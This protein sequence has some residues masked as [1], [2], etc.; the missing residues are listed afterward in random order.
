MKKF[1]TISAF[2]L[3]TTIALSGCSSQQ[4]A[5]QPKT[6]NEAVSQPKAEASAPNIKEGVAKL[7]K[8][9]KQVRKAATSGDQAKV[10]ENGP[11]LEE[12]WSSFEDGVKEKYPD[13]YKNIEKY[14][15]PAIAAA[16]A[17][18]LDKDA[19]LKLDNQLIDELFSFSAQL[20]PVSQIQAGAT[21]MLET[22]KQLKQ[23]IQAG[24]QAKV[25]ELGPKLEKSWSSFEDGVKPRYGDLYE[26]LEKPLNPEVA[27]SQVT[28]LD[29]E[30]MNKLNEDLTQ[31]LNELVQKA[32]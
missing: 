26:R 7:L 12:V 24:D 4:T 2:A 25:K 13:A 20:I 15:N 1:A 19:L 16:K 8:T 6:S 29:K 10:K 28:P 31:V 18:P 30:T 9:A 17:D 3:V 11:K 23:A 27:G 32:K 21:E 22:T 5:P 14:L